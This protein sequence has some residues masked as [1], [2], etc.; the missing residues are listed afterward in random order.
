MECPDRWSGVGEV[1]P[2]DTTLLLHILARSS[3]KRLINELTKL[4]YEI[5]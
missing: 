4:I 2:I 5:N 3:I 1:Q